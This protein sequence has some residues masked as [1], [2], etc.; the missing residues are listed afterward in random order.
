M[1][2]LS[3]AA[4]VAAAPLQAQGN[5][6]AQTV[7]NANAQNQPANDLPIVLAQMKANKKALVAQNMPLTQ[8]QAD[9]FWPVYDAYQADLGKL[10]DRSIALITNYA[11]NY[12]S[13]GDTVAANLTNA[14]VQI[15]QDRVGLMR[16]YLPRF[17]KVLPPKLVARYYQIENK[18]RAALMYS[19]AADIPLVQ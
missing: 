4:A 12:T 15:E 9:A 18:L 14:M 10:T 7:P 13:M 11:N 16:S 5:T 2:V 3:L 6:G 1:F 19:L 8:G 17:Q